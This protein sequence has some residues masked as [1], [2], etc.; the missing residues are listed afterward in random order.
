MGIGFALIVTAAIT[1]IAIITIAKILN[2]LE[3]R[4]KNG[5]SKSGFERFQD[6][7]NEIIKAKLDATQTHALND[8]LRKTKKGSLVA[9]DLDEDKN[10][11]NVEI[12]NTNRVD[13]EVNELLDENDGLLLAAL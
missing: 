7:I 13:N 11:S 3:E 10:I 6:I 1:F 5:A 4:L 12:I 2:V 9:F 8:L